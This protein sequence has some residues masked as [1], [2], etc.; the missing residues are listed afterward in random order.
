M[1][2]ARTQSLIIRQEGQK[3]STL[4]APE[5]KFAFFPDGAVFRRREHPGH[6]LQQ[7]AQL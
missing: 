7:T 4:S 6:M 5:L 2:E 3:T 1:A